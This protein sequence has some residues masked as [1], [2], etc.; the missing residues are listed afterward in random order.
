MLCNVLA[1]ASIIKNYKE[2]EQMTVN[3]SYSLNNMAM[4]RRIAAF[5]PHGIEVT[6]DTSGYLHALHVD[7][8]DETPTLY[9]IPSCSMMELRG[10]VTDIELTHGQ[11][12]QIITTAV[13]EA[14]DFSLIGLLFDDYRKYCKSHPRLF[15]NNF[16]GYMETHF[17]ENNKFT[18]IQAII[19]NHG[20][21]YNGKTDDEFDFEVP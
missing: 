8:D 7:Y 4:L 20:P 1:E 3:L 17:V 2:H 16:L 15:I 11:L 19:D 10:E 13:G 9:D 5:Q 14:H 18:V 6:Q 12:N 21:T